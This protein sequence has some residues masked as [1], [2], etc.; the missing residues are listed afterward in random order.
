MPN[1]FH[2]D[3]SPFDSLSKQE[4]TLV[5]DSV[6]IAY[7][8]K[9]E[10]ILDVGD[11]PRHLYVIIK[12]HVAQ[13]EGSELLHLYGPDDTFDGRGLVAGRSSHRFIAQDEVLAY[14]LAH[15]AVM[16]LI[17]SNTTF[18]ALLFSNLGDKLSALGRRH[19]EREM[20]SLTLA[21]LDEAVLH[22]PHYVDADTD[23]LAVARIFEQARTTHVL[24]R[25]DTGTL[26]RLGI[27]SST[28]LPRAILDGRPLDDLPVGDLATYELV[29]LRPDDLMGEALT[30]MLRHRIHRIVVADGDEVLGVLESLD[31]FSFLSNHSHLIL[32][33]IDQA[34]SLQALADASAQTPRM[35]QQLHASGTDVGLIGD[36]VQEINAR[37]F[38]RA[39]QLIAPP[40]LVHNSCLIVMGSEGRGEQLLKTD[41]DNGLILRDGYTPPE[42]LAA[43]CDRFSAALAQFGYPPCP[44]RIM[45][46]NP[47]WR[48]SAAEWSTRT[49]TWLMGGQ[50][51][52]LMNLAIFLDAHPVCGDERLLD[53]V[54]ERLREV[55][56]DNDATLS[57]FASA[58]DAFGTS[59]H[60]LGRLFGLGED[61]DEA[62]HIKK[63][64]IFPIVH[65]V[66]SLA[67]AEHIESTGTVERIR[68]L[69]QLGVLKPSWGDSLIHSLHFFM[70]LR[71][72]AALAEME[73]GRPVSGTVV[74]SQLS[75][76]DRSLLKDS[77]GIVKRF[78]AMLHQ[79]F[80]LDA[81]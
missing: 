37:L 4:Q 40:E 59:S 68:A 33:R 2:F 78:K 41:Q 73:T 46:D 54:R 72:K 9:D 64:G 30:M 15:E 18:S 69:V 52:Q 58:I 12:G 17:A 29:T 35:V 63:H 71:L 28:A 70:G 11:V 42:N 80:R 25:D 60:W 79:R 10:V 43:L 3:A 16:S 55:A 21:R 1:A 56:T 13:M 67:L 31:V 34:T 74:A 47:E 6:D 38:E 19:S 45:V 32:T 7:F 53:Q 51:P 81:M 44:G 20:Q 76:L 22:P 23:I 48:G 36:L 26:P 66:R 50:P 75:S 61:T 57:R 14:E 62:L 8:R 24:V 65:G 77:L 39:W 27:F 49:R 5:R